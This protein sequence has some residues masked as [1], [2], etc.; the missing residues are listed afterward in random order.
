M[1]SGGGSNNTRKHLPEGI[2]DNMELIPGAVAVLLIAD[3]DVGAGIVGLMG[4]QGFRL[5]LRTSFF[6]VGL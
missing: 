3:D 2:G 4:S 6:F 1:I 5:T